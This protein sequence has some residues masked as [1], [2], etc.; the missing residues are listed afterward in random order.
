ME[1]VVVTNKRTGKHSA[2]CIKKLRYII[3]NYQLVKYIMCNFSVLF[4]SSSQRP[5]RLKS[6]LK[7]MNLEDAARGG[8]KITVVRQPKGPDGTEGFNLERKVDH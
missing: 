1:F 4:F 8:R 7:S 2:C 6:K 3:C 5:E